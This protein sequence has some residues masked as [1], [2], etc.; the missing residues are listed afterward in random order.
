M[1]KNNWNWEG[2]KVFSIRQYEEANKVLKNENGSMPV[3]YDHE[4]AMEWIN[5]L[6]NDY[7]LKKFTIEKV[8]FYPKFIRKRYDNDN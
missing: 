6:E 2:D 8:I 5:S 4:W 1:S 7:K 3:I